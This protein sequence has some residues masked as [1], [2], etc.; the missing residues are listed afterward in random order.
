MKHHPI[1]RQ[2][3]ALSLTALGCADLPEDVAATRAG[4]GT[5]GTLNT[6]LIG[7]HDFGADQN[8]GDFAIAGAHAYVARRSGGFA[9]VDISARAAPTVVSTIVPAV[10]AT[11]VT[12]VATLNIAGTD[13]LFVGNYGGAPDPAYGNFTGVYI[14]SLANPAAPSLVRAITYGAG[15]GYHLASQV[16]TLT[17]AELGG[18]SFLFV[19]SVMSSGIEVFE[20]TTPAAPTYFSSIIRQ[21]ISTGASIR[22]MRVQG[23]RLYAAWRVGFAVYDLSTFPSIV[24]NYYAPPQPPILV[25]KLYTGAA[26][27]AAA[28]TPSGDYVLTADDVTAGRVRVWDVRVP[29]AVAQVSIFGGSA[30]TIARQVTVQGN[31]AWVAHQQDGLRVFDISNPAAPVSLA[32]FDTDLAVPSNRRYGGWDVIP[33]GDTAWF[34]DTADGLHAI[35]IEDTL[36]VQSATWSSGQQQLVVNTTSSL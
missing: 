30:A 16:R 29:S 34:T 4:L 14:Y 36:T 18:R 27:T 9:V 23:G 3:I 22:D 28:P 26:T 33:N 31:L 2:A 11:D 12:D 35:N 20:V 25:A 21:R 6:S 19:G 32:W 13:Y 15:G 5:P 8:T 7:R 24:P 10:G 17:A 1:L